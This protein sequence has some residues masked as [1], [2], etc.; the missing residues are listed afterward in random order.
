MKNTDK[1]F[2]LNGKVGLYALVKNK[3]IVYIGISRN[4]YRRILEHIVNGFSFN[5]GQIKIWEIEYCNRLEVIEAMLIRRIRPKYNKLMYDD[6]NTF[7]ISKGIE[8]GDYPSYHVYSKV[9]KQMKS[10]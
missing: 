10:F 2:H 1:I 4:I 8:E 9:F 3:E 6:I 5:L 7:M